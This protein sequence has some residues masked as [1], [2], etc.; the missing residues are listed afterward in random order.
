MASRTRKISVVGARGVG[1]STL[2]VQYVD[3][4]F[5][6]SY[7]PTIQNQFNKSISFRGQTYEVEVL[8]TAGQD[9]FTILQ[10]SSTLVH[11]YILVY[12]VNSR[13][14]FE[15][16]PVIRDKIL[17]STGTDKVPMILVGNKLDLERK[18]GHEEGVKL[19][20]EFGIPYIEISAKTTSEQDISRIFVGLLEQIEGEKIDP[21]NEKCIIM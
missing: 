1:K 13:S 16:L 3:N 21:E 6:E 18:V 11:G 8:D 20:R 2:V 17:E 5:L 10:D 12:A 14:S 9:E 19:A 4:Y 7:Y 15:L